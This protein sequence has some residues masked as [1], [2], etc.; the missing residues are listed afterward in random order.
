[1]IYSLDCFI[2]NNMCLNVL[3]VTMSVC[4]SSGYLRMY[5][6][7]YINAHVILKHMYSTG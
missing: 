3:F 5:Y 4:Y 2:L 7:Q 1:M 6:Q